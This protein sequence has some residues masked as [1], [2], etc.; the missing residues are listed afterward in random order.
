MA[1]QAP[2]E[3]THFGFVVNAI[4]LQVD[5]QIG[6]SLRVQPNVGI[7]LTSAGVPNTVKGVPIQ[8]NHF[9]LTIS[10]TVGGKPYVRMPTQ[11]NTIQSFMFVNSYK[12]SAN[13]PTVNNNLTPTVVRASA[14]RPRSAA[15][16]RLTR[17]TT[18]P[19]CPSC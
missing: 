5:V 14:T 11:C 8:V 19:P 3:V 2:N 17:P 10:G 9:G 7:N 15:R 12:S 4:I 18:A 6:A 16:S 13:S 1:P